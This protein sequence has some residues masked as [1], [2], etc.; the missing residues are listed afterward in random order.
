[1]PHASTIASTFVST[2]AVALALRLRRLCSLHFCHS[3]H[4]CLHIVSAFFAT[5]NSAVAFTAPTSASA[6]SLLSLPL[7]PKPLSPLLQPLPP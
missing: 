6:L 2:I 7:L 1:L 4:L 3:H 5:I